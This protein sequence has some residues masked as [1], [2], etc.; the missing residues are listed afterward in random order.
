LNNLRFSDA[1]WEGKLS[2]TSGFHTN[3]FRFGE[4]LDTF[5]RSGFDVHRSRVIRWQTRP[6][7][8]AKLD[9]SFRQL[10]DEDLLLSGFDVVLRRKG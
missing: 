8:S 7:P 10:Q 4:M 6:P 5:K 3:R 1:G 9:A 2:R